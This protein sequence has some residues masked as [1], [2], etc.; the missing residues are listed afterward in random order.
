MPVFANTCN[1]SLF[2]RYNEQSGVYAS[3]YYGG[4]GDSWESL[5]MG[6]SINRNF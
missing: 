6:F 5:Q 3:S 4:T 1:A 2:V